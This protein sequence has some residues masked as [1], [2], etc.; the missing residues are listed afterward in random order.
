MIEVSHI[1]VFD[2]C[3]YKYI[4]ICKN[5]HTVFFTPVVTESVSS[6]QLFERAVFFCVEYIKA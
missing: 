1:V 4:Y 2:M 6:F 3:M 5:L